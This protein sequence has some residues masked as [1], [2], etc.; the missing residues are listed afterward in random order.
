MGRGG[1]LP[2][3]PAAT[4]ALGPNDTPPV[5]MPAVRRPAGAH[6]PRT[7]SDTAATVGAAGRNGGAR[8]ARGALGVL[9]DA[10]ETGPD[11]V[12]DDD[13]GD[14]DAGAGGVGA[15]RAGGRLTHLGPVSPYRF[16]SRHRVPRRVRLLLTLLVVAALMLIGAFAWYETTASG[17]GGGKTVVV[18][19]AKGEGMSAITSAL[20]TDGVISS[21]FA[22]RLSLFLHGTPQVQPGGY[23]LHTGESFG[24][25]RARLAAGPNVFLVNVPSGFTIAELGKVL[26]TVSGGLSATFVHDATTG[27]VPSPFQAAPGTSLEGLLGT[28][29]YELLPGESAKELLTHMVRRFEQ[30]AAA[31]GLT[32][33][34]AA[35]LG[36]TPYQ[37]VTVASI[38]QKEGYYAKYM[39]PVARV[40]YNRL[41]TGMRLGMTS[42]VLYALG[43]DG[44]QIT[45]ADHTYT[46]PYN[47][48]LNA[49]LT[50]TPI[51]F[52]SLTALKAAVSPPAGTWLYFDLTTAKKGV[53]VF[54]NTLTQQ[55]AAEQ[56]AQANA[57]AHG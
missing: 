3:E 14:D 57:S 50:P 49:G 27:V 36:Y 47:T 26:K 7:A 23:V 34:S 39:G 54:S 56:Q 5:G 17:S 22:F 52:P 4:P 32:P 11:V 29:K 41:R 1:G 25:V 9:P 20:A 53:M 37:V 33:A 31:A 35:Q 48:Y 13:V 38:V 55:L 40:I 43:Q 44:G 16:R 12:G 15:S 19:V 21:S 8:P 46:S 24:D 18:H 10:Q 30:Q 45:S 51:C 28:G 42:T 6:A 2:L